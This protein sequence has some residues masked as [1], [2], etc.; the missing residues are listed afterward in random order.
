MH[1]CVFGERRGV[2]SE[3]IACID[4]PALV[5]AAAALASTLRPGQVVAL[6]GDLGSGKT[7]FVRGAVQALHG[8]DAAVTSPTFLFRQ[9]YEGKPPIEHVDLYRL[10][11]PAEAAEL[12]LEDA[13]AP[14]AITF[15]E[16]PE[17]LPALLPRAAIAVRIS[18]AGDEPRT[19]RIER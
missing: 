15:V 19:V 4:R 8:S 6:Q 9:R 2:A 10:D 16:W 17:R 11:D 7:T 1:L 12:G 18:G 13:F 5:A 14:D 3:I